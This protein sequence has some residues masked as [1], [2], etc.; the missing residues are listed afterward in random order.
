MRFVQSALLWA[1][2]GVQRTGVLRSSPG[3]AAF[4]AAYWAYKS[5][6]EARDLSALRPF[7][8]PGSTVIDVGANIGFFAVRFAQWTGPTGRV[9][10]IEPEA[11]NFAS[12]SARIARR[13]VADRTTLVRA[14]VVEAPG[15][16]FL[17]LN[18][19]HPADHRVA[20]SGERVEAVSVDAMLEPHP[21]SRVS[22]VKVDVQ[23]GELRVLRGARQTLERWRPALF[24][25]FHEPSLVMAGTS[26]RELLEE[27][28]ALGYVPHVLEGD[29]TWRRVEGDGLFQRMRTRGYVDVLLL[30]HG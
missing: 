4:E 3:R 24:V 10:A 21:E 7:V 1:Y 28:T 9:I 8:T 17:Q 2:R 23:G 29:G 25:E 15:Q 30:A 13:G 5:L 14:A 18:P 27:A 20:D 16:V 11:A 19:D 6:I 22:L 12:L 26:P